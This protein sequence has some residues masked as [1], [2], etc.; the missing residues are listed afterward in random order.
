[1][2]LETADE[3]LSALLEQGG[4][5]TDRSLEL[6]GAHGP[7]AKQAVVQRC[8]GQPLAQPSV[9]TCMAAI[10]QSVDDVRALQHHL[11]APPDCSTTCRTT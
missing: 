6:L 9:V 8:S 2:D 11:T 1:M 10:N 4:R 7:E 5:L 3:A